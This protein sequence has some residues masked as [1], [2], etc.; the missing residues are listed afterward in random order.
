MRIDHV[1]NVGIG[2]ANP[3]CELDVD[4]QARI[5][6]ITEDTTLAQF[7][8]KDSTGKIFCRPP[9]SDTLVIKDT[10]VMYDTIVIIQVIFDS[11]VVKKVRADTII[12]LVACL[13]EIKTERIII[14][15]P[16][17]SNKISLTDAMGT[18]IIDSVDFFETGL[19]DGKG[20]IRAG[21]LSTGDVVEIILDPSTGKICAKGIF[22]IE[23]DGH[24]IEIEPG[25]STSI[26]V[27]DTLGNS[28]DIDIDPSTG[29]IDVGGELTLYDPANAS[30]FVDLS[31]SGI[32]FFC[33]S[34]VVE[35]DKSSNKVSLTATNANTGEA[36]GITIDNENGVTCIN[37]DLK[38]END[39]SKMVFKPL[40]IGGV[41][42]FTDS[43]G[44]DIALQFNPGAD[45]IALAGPNDAF[46]VIDP[47]NVLVQTQ[48]NKDGFAKSDSSLNTL[49]IKCGDQ[50]GKW[51]IIAQ[52]AA[53]GNTTGLVID[54]NTQEIT[55]IGK[56][57]MDS[58]SVQGDLEVCGDIVLKGMLQDTSGNNLLAGSIQNNTPDG[59]FL[60]GQN[61][62]IDI[63]GGAEIG[64]D[65]AVGGGA[66]VVGDA[67][68]CGDLRVKGNIIDSTGEIRVVGDFGNDYASLGQGG[69]SVFSQFEGAGFSVFNDSAF[70]GMFMVPFSNAVFFDSP[71]TQFFGDLDVFGNLSKSAGSF[72]I[73]HPLQPR[74]KYLVHSFVESPDMMNVYNGNIT[75]D[76]N[77]EAWVQLP[78]Y[79]EALNMDFRYQLTVIGD[80][81]QAIIS[82][83]IAGNKFQIRTDK[84]DIKVSWQVTGV[85]N[86]TY[87][88]ENRI[89]V[90]P[91]K[92]PDQI[93]KLRYEPQNVESLD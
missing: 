67:E 48:M 41:I 74:D 61:A 11:I 77:G 42:S 33:D 32:T 80:F 22:K 29:R 91:D 49:E 76:Q 84:P 9:F 6:Q 2:T 40:E 52:D 25:P 92:E 4:G 46:Y 53:G 72:K 23:K 71:L 93:G 5:R 66:T 54:G 37:G 21:D 90:E 10:L 3:T 50:P 7:L 65:I 24:K 28:M 59:D 26:T 89:E 85:R 69:L 45:C 18:V 60:T 31:E 38:V 15:D 81:A 57:K 82:Q 19:E 8:V 35:L 14:T 12:A 56:M 58:T 27:M 13:K 63:T 73:D 1:G 30:N 62:G 68:I 34:T 78:D 87:A 64:G 36:T 88:R 43:S 75:T 83:E 79:F 16:T 51:G 70:L 17:D 39:Y 47:N 55:V 86:D 20:V 44:N